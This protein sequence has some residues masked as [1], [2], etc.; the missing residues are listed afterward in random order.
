MTRSAADLPA[1][2]LMDIGLPRMN[3]FQV[4]SEMRKTAGLLDSTIVGVSGFGM[5]TDTKRAID[6]GIDHYVIKPANPS[7]FKELIS[8]VS[9]ALR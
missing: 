4:A 1:T 2:Q 3:G 9:K 7:E 6:S 8:R 5:P